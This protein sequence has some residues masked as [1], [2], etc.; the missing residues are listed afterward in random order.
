MRGAN[1]LQTRQCLRCGE[2][3]KLTRRHR[4][5]CTS[6]CRSRNGQDRA[7]AEE[8][9][10]SA[11]SRTKYR[12]NMELFERVRCLSQLYFETPRAKRLGHLQ[13]LVARARDGDSRT[14]AVL[15]NP[16]LIKTIDNHFADIMRRHRLPAT[17]GEVVDWYCRRFWNASGRDVVNGAAPEPPTGEIFTLTAKNVRPDPLG[18]NDD[19]DRNI[20]TINGSIG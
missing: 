16:Y 3:F 1:K 18:K 14:R 6:R 19:R 20:S 8:P 13:S 2:E 7:R 9:V 5:Y 15:A 17:I 12:D 10:N 4:K 11:N